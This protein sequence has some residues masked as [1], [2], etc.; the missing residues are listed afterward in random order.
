MLRS[1]IHIYYWSKVVDAAGGEGEPEFVTCL[2]L[3]CERISVS[4]WSSKEKGEVCVFLYIS[5]QIS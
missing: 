3:V 1:L 4:F 2:K 5:Q